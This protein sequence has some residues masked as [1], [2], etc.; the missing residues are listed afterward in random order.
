M[1]TIHLLYLLKKHNAM[2]AILFFY[3]S[4]VFLLVKFIFEWGE[5]TIVPVKYSVV[6]YFKWEV[7]PIKIFYGI[8]YLSFAYCVYDNISGGVLD[9]SHLYFFLGLCVVVST[10]RSIEFLNHKLI[11]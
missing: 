1:P 4:A 2:I 11:P 9:L 10:L 8:P 3:V 7:W 6:D 5:F